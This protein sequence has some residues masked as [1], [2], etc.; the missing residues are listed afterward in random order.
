MPRVARPK[1]FSFGLSVIVY[2]PLAPPK[3]DV[4][5]GEEQLVVR[6]G[7]QPHLVERRVDIAG[8]DLKGA[9]LLSSSKANG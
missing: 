4:A 7:R 8:L 2:R 9:G 5:V 1:W 3:P 6:R